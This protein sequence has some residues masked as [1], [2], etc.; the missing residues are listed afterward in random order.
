MAG[1]QL[2][3]D[4]QSE[5]LKAWW[6]ENGTSVIAGTVLG[7]A[8]IVGVNYWRSYQADQAETAAALYD[9]LLSQRG[10]AAADAGRKLIDEYAGTPYAGKAAL[11]LAK[12][13]FEDGDAEQAAQHL[14]W[15]MSE[16]ADPA[17]RDVA[18]L[19]LVRVALSGGDAGRAG[20]LLAD[21]DSG[22]YES[23]YRELLGDIAMARGEPAAARDEYEAALATLP[24]QSGFATMLNRKLDAAIGA[25]K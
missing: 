25:S 16:A 6:K 1:L 22:G 8:I 19:R 4:E 24:Q 23:E 15:A 11:M 10:G 13:A 17:D 3:D 5:R 18:R 12:L 21:M 9:E 2:S 14:E 20:A 7:I